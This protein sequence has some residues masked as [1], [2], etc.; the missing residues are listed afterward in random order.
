MASDHAVSD[1]FQ[2]KLSIC[3]EKFILGLSKPYW[4]GKGLLLGLGLGNSE[5][6][7]RTLDHPHMRGGEREIPRT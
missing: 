5:Q 1:D 7:V 3:V 6:N 2:K 4:K